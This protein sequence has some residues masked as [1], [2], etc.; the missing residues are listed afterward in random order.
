MKKVIVLFLVIIP[1]S[2]FSQLAITGKVQ[3]SVTHQPVGYASIFLSNTSIGSKTDDNG[4]FILK[5]V[6]PGKYEIIVSVLGYETYANSITI[7]SD[8][9]RLQDILIVPKTLQLVGVVI[10][11]NRDENREDYLASFKEEFIGKS[12]LAADCKILNPEILDFDYDKATKTL[13][14]TAPDFLEID[15]PSLGYHIKY[16]LHDF[17]LVHKGDTNQYLRFQGWVLFENMKGSASKQHVWQKQRLMDYE[18]SPLQFLRDITTPQGNATFPKFFQDGFWVMR[19]VTYANPERPSDSVIWVKINYF[20]KS[21]DRAHKDSLNKWKSIAAL[22]KI[23]K[24]LYPD[25]LS[26][27]DFVKPTDQEGIYALGLTSKSYSLFINYQKDRLR[28]YHGQ[29]LK[30]SV[31][32]I[33]N[34]GYPSNTENTVVSFNSP[35]AFFDGNGQVLEMSITRMAFSGL[36]ARRRVADLLPTDYVPMIKKK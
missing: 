3:N 18:G 12:P 10:K 28:N 1:L 15:N 7:N 35:Y 29:A 24:K 13:N 32:P 22:P 9:L 26:A 2:C 36:W 34:L 30:L 27:A 33:N 5:N 6:Q 8:S 11:A 14:V 31:Q 25:T 23:L 21:E 4:K 19:L 17:Q 16:L 20:K